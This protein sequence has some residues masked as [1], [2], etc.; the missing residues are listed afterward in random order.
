MC[1]T[2]YHITYCQACNAYID[3][4]LVG[5]VV[6]GR[7]DRNEPCEAEK[8]IRETPVPGPCGTCQPPPR[9]RRSRRLW[10]RSLEQSGK[11]DEESADNSAVDDGDDDSMDSSTD[12]DGSS[13]EDT[14]DGD[15]QDGD[16][17]NNDMKKKDHKDGK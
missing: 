14:N 4:H 16:Y 12:G 6:C 1:I 7:H 3:S 2:W 9:L 15:S 8:A 13:D 5:T 11:N 17:I 10:L